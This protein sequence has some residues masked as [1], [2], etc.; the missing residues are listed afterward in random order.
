MRNAADAEAPV[1]LKRLP[2]PPRWPPLEVSV[3]LPVLVVLPLLSL[4]EA[5]VPDAEGAAASPVAPAAAHLGSQQGREILC[6]DGASYP[7]GGFHVSDG[8]RD[9]GHRV[10]NLPVLLRL[11]AAMESIGPRPARRHQRQGRPPAPAARTETRRPCGLDDCGTV[12]LLILDY[13]Y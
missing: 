13:G 6:V 4:E 10:D 8:H 7:D 11:P 5:E 12:A 1:S 9:G 3:P 2:P